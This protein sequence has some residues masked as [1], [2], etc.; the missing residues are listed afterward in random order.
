[1]KTISKNIGKTWKKFFWTNFNKIQR[2][3]LNQGKFGTNCA[4]EAHQ[5]IGGNN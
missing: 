3:L 4:V 5:N 1:M 2:F